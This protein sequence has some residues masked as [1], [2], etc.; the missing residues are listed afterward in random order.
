MFFFG[1][2]IFAFLW[3][4]ILLFL[5]YR[6]FHEKYF[7]PPLWIS[8]EHKKKIYSVYCMLLLYRFSLAFFW[9]L[10]V[11]QV[12]FSPM[13]REQITVF[14]MCVF[15]LIPEK[16]YSE[17]MCSCMCVLVCACE[18]LCLLSLSSSSSMCCCRWS[19]VHFA[20]LCC[21]CVHIF[22]VYWVVCTYTQHALIRSWF[23]ASSGTVPAFQLDKNHARKPA[24]TRLHSQERLGFDVCRKTVCWKQSGLY[25]YHIFLMRG[26]VHSISCRKSSLA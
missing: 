19:R 21:L 14:S 2:L 24:F 3:I 7:L 26:N 4:T 20:L 16:V 10:D 22:A 23:E 1:Y 17:R 12:V 8:I 18:F 13:F 15:L 6:N 11:Q 9:R 5:F 25:A